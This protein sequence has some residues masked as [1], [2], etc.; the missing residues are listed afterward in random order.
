MQFRELTDR[1]WDLIRQS[2]PPPAYTGRPRADDRTTINGILFVIMSGCRWMDMPSKYGSH[3]T[4]WERHKKWSERG[5]WKAVMDSLVSHGYQ[6][7][8]VDA[9]DLSIDSS[10][11]HAKKGGRRLATTAT[12]RRKVARYMR[13]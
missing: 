10:T 8:L 13:Q 9:D 12:R 5:V 7:G 1:Q 11:V 4:A 3:K 6:T 2:L